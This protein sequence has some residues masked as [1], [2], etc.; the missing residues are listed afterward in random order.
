M[1]SSGARIRTRAELF[2]GGVSRR[3]LDA[4]QRNGSLTRLRRG[5]YADANTCDIARRAA[6]LGGTLACVSAARHE[7][8]WV[9]SP[10]EPLHVAV[11]PD[12][13]RRSDGAVIHWDRIDHDAFGPPHVR[14]VLRQILRC[15]GVEDFLVA[16]ESAL[17]QRRIG[18]AD[19]TWLAAN[20]NETGREAIAF[21]RADAESGLETLVRW[22]LRAWGIR[23]R[24]QQNLVS[25][26]RVDLLLG[27]RLVV[28]VDGVENHASPEHRHRDL[29][30]D[31]NAAAWGFVTLRFDY[32]MVIHDWPTVELALRG[33]LDRGIHLSDR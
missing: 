25:V 9:L 18:G 10:A 3:R 28:E 16:L 12:G 14:E 19:L 17:H 29:V 22:R 11:R 8:L 32:A 2:S 21:A 7:G 13:H 1:C 6:L 30:R 31:A 23:V 27:E 4:A 33:L 15:C 24:T 26:G 5:V 20:T